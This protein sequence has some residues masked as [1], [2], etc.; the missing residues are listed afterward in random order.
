MHYLKS[1]LAICKQVLQFLPKFERLQNASAICDCY[2]QLETAKKRNVA[3]G[4][5]CCRE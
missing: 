1:Y 4:L 5:K 2:L 3:V